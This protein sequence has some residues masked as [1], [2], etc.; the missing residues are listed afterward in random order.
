MGEAVG[1]IDTSHDRSP[2]SPAETGASRSCNFTAESNIANPPDDSGHG[3]ETAGSASSAPSKF[4]GERSLP[5][6]V[7]LSLS[8]FTK[9]A[10]SG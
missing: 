5:P 10:T 1:L 7:H 3:E 2:E 6:R 9:I 8:N 4:L